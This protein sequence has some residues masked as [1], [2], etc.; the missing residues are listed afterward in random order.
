MNRITTCLEFLRGFRKMGIYGVRKSVLRGEAIIHSMFNSKFWTNEVMQRRKNAKMLRRLFL[1]VLVPSVILG[2]CSTGPVPKVE[3]TNAPASKA[4]PEWVGN[5]AIVDGIASTGCVLWA[6]DLSLDRAEAV[7]EARAALAKTIDIKIRAMDKTYGN[8]NRTV[9]GASWGGVFETTSKQ[10]TERYLSASHV[11]N[12]DIV[13][14]EKK[15]H[16]CAMV[17]IEGVASRK[18]FDEIVSN[19]SGAE[20]VSPQDESVLWEVFKANRGQE[21]LSEETR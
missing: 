10:V 21:E 4:L 17:A 11:V 3:N 19:S 1:V 20:Q 12:V 18:L 7:A 8:K 6:G 9:N 14:I 5:P 15:K 2:G 16:L 13:K